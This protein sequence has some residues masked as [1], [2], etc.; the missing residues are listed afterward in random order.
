MSGRPRFGEACPELHSTLCGS[1][2]TVGGV[3]QRFRPRDLLRPVVGQVLKGI[4]MPD[5]PDGTG[6]QAKRQPNRL[7]DLQWLANDIELDERRVSR[8]DDF[9][10]SGVR[11]LPMLVGFREHRQSHVVVA[12]PQVGRERH[13]TGRL[14][15][16]DR[17]RVAVGDQQELPDLAGHRQLEHERVNAI[18]A[19][20]LQ[21]DVEPKAAVELQ[22]AFRGDLETRGLPSRGDGYLIREITLG[23]AGLDRQNLHL[24]V[25]GPQNHPGC[26]A[27]HVDALV[28]DLSREGRLA[29]LIVSAPHAQALLGASDRFKGRRDRMVDPQVVLPPLGLGK[30]PE[31]LPGGFQKLTV[32]IKRPGLDDV[33]AGLEVL[34]LDLG[35]RGRAPELTDG[36]RRRG[37]TDRRQDPQRDLPDLVADHPHVGGEF[38]DACVGEMLH[39][40]A[41]CGRRAEQ[42]VL[43]KELRP[44][45]VDRRQSQHVLAGLEKLC[46]DGDGGTV[47]EAEGLVMDAF[48]QG[49]EDFAPERDDG[50]ERACQGETGDR[51]AFRV[52]ANAFLT[53]GAR[54]PGEEKLAKRRGIA[55]RATVDE[56]PTRRVGEPVRVIDKEVAAPDLARFRR[57]REPQR[58]V[59]QMDFGDPFPGFGAGLDVPFGVVLGVGP[60]PGRPH[61]VVL[62]PDRAGHEQMVRRRRLRGLQVGL[63]GILDVDRGVATGQRGPRRS[64]AGQRDLHAQVHAVFR[65]RR[66][67]RRL[68]G[69]QLAAR[70]LDETRYSAGLFPEGVVQ[71]SVERGRPFQKRQRRPGPAAQ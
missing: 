17:R 27:E 37:L 36:Q 66:Q 55:E 34:G 53:K 54:L 47:G 41:K 13:G 19:G 25:A 2:A 5:G 62:S 44:G 18:R 64:A 48:S 56:G 49:V 61:E 45:L 14:Y 33:G 69:H 4:G 29:G 68:V 23:R 60:L 46:R 8:R 51:I 1:D 11:R 3:C 40:Q 31:R 59:R 50:R 35:H 38:R 39:E 42:N 21:I 71:L 43:P 22:R 57:A 16:R 58:P 24:L 6:H 7:G 20:G 63:E 12:D 28:D 15:R 32:P 30:D 26:G 9:N 70:V 10:H 65:V 52:A 67:N